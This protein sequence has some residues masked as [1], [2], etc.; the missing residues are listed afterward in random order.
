MKF[1]LG[2]F[3]NPFVDT[4]A[5][6]SVFDNAEQ[7]SLARLTAQKSMV[8]LKNE[9][10]LL[11]LSKTLKK[12]AVIGP[13]GNNIRNLVGD[14]AYPCHIESLLEMRNDDNVFDTPMP[15]AVEVEH[16]FNAMHTIFEAVKDKVSKDT[17]VTY[18]QGC[19]IQGL[20]ESQ[21][22]EAVRLATE[23]DVVIAVV[24]DRAGLTDWCTTGESRDS[25]SIRLM[26]VQERLVQRLID[27]G[28]PTVVVLV[29]GRPLAT[30]W[31]ADNAQAILEAWLPGEEGAHAVADVLFGDYNPS[32]RLPITIPRSVGQVPI[33]YG[34]KPSGGRSH[35]KGNYVDESNLPLY[36]FGYGLSYTTF[37]YRDLSIS[38]T[39][40]DVHGQVDVTCTVENVGSSDG[41]EVVQLYIHDVEADVTRPVLELKGFVRVALKTGESKRVTFTLSAHQ[42]GFYNRALQYVVE[43]GVVEV[44]VGSASND[45]RLN[46]AFHVT[47][48]TVNVE[49]SKVFSTPVRIE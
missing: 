20:D 27:S 45:I 47:G 23:S 5:T 35:W 31:I 12:I 36:A 42:L 25:A 14:Y 44:Y 26:G 8:L 15:E 16:Q 19:D 39:D 41:E 6:L 3:E 22:D 9:K 48:K 40:V 11:P 7:R 32:G 24:G 4:T 46:G 13:N 30:P 34:H 21:F 2:L 17:M 43:P 37:A 38:A 29:S 49:D 18:M 28:T 10:A 33:Y 1:Q